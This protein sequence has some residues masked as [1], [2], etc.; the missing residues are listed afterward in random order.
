MIG[1]RERHHREQRERD[2]DLPA[3]VRAKDTGHLHE[4][5]PHRTAVPGLQ[6]AKHDH[7]EPARVEQE[8]E[9]EHEHEHQVD[10][11]REKGHDRAGRAFGERWAVLLHELADA[12]LDAGRE[13]D[14]PDDQSPLPLQARPRMR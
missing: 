9:G 5:P 3:D 13:H 2:D 11:Q 6:R 8:I 14:V 12:V 4:D 7:P 10:D 1:Q